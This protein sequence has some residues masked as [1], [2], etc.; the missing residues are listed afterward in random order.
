MP[1]PGVAG[2]QPSVPT[3]LLV[4]RGS[5]FRGNDSAGGAIGLIADYGFKST[6]TG[7]FSSI[8]RIEMRWLA[9]R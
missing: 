6:G 8:N 3:G 1:M 5:R 2:L 9:L 7:G 4:N